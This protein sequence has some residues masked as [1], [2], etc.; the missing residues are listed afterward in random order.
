MK[1][2]ILTLSSKILDSECIE[3]CI[4][5]IIIFFFNY[6]SQN[7]KV[8]TF[9]IALNYLQFSAIVKKRL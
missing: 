3:D 7:E 6:G 5:F 2:I 4:D 8:K 9:K 1:K